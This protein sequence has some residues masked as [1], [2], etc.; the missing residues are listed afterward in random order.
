ML[1]MLLAV[2]M[3]V[4][5]AS[6]A[7][8]NTLTA[9]EQKEGFELLFD[10]KSLSKFKVSPE[11]AKAWRVVDGAI[12]TD[13]QVGGG[14][15]LTNEEFTDFVLKA[16]F[17]AHPDINSGIM[18]RNPHPQFAADGSRV[19]GGGRG[20]ELQIRDKDPGNYTGGSFLTAS[21]VGVGKAPADAKI[22]PG[23]WNTLEVT[24]TGNHFVVIYNG[25]KVVDA[26]DAKM[27]SA[28]GAIGLQLAHPE[29]ARHA[30]VEFRNLKIKRL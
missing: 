24:V 30:D 5:L 22:K 10:G 27:Q 20:Y 21:V 19:R 18:L 25:A 3:S 9:Q 13:A 1:V 16:E 11:Q 12:K 29:D 6:A 26:D 4:G 2:G 23:E 8:A 15:I 28:K 14:T 7:D 17:R